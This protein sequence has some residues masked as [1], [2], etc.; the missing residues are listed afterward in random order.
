MKEKNIFRRNILYKQVWREPVTLVA[1]KYGIPYTTLR[2]ICSDLNVPLPPNGYW[3]KK[4][5]GKAVEQTPLPSDQGI[6]TIEAY[7]NRKKSMPL[8]GYEEQKRQEII[9]VSKTIAVANSKAQRFYLADIAVMEARQWNAAMIKDK[10]RQR[11]ENNFSSCQ[12]RPLLADVL[13][14]SGIERAANL[15]DALA[16]A[17]IEL[18]GKVEKN[19]VF[20]INNRP[21]PISFYERQD[22]VEHAV[23]ADEK[24][25]LEKYGEW[26][27]S[28]IRKYD[29][30]FN[31]ILCI[32]IS[33]K[34]PSVTIRRRDGL[35]IGLAIFS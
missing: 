33:G 35:K 31:G 19:A 21:V 18:G 13:S 15:F 9:H 32:R 29:Y 34:R 28:K 16:R 11:A 25:M 4:K 2:K 30:V 7:P 26:Y 22:M 3:T 27:Q 5:A 8:Y 12:D 14:D 17:V 24:K 6:T 1:K 23:T 20:Y 10:K